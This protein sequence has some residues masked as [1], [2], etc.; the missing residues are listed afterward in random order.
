MKIAVVSLSQISAGKHNVKDPR[1]DQ[2]HK[3]TGSKKETYIQVEIVSEE[4]I[5]EADALLA[6]VAAKQDLILRDLEL[7]ET[8]LGRSESESEKALLAKLKAHLEKEEF[9]LSLALSEEERQ[10]LSTYGLITARPVVLATEEEAQE[11]N[12]LL[13]RAVKEAGYISFFTAGEKETR[14][15]LIK[16]GTTAWEAAGAVHSDIQKGFIRAEIIAFGDFV[17]AGSE[18]AAKQAGKLRLENKD[19]CM[20]DADWT[21]FRFNK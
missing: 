2:M 10:G 5:L 6:G 4:N 14:A 17:A 7:V 20:Q 11:P 13:S 8:R 16:A 21:N 19:Y 9:V 1:L 15:W 18:A 12:S 3:I